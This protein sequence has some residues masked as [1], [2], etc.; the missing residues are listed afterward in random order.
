MRGLSQAKKNNKNIVYPQPRI[1]DAIDSFN[2]KNI[3]HPF[4]TETRFCN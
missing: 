1:E 2:G 4:T 3:V